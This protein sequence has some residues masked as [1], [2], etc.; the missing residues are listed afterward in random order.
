MIAIDRI[1]TSCPCIEF[2]P[3]PQR[4]DPSQS[5]AVTVR[6]RPEESL[7]FRGRLA[8]KVTGISPTGQLLF[9][10]RVCVDLESADS[11]RVG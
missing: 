6:F 3:L 2:G 5:A 7:D 4:V 8:I 11:H 10:T 1:E 9:S